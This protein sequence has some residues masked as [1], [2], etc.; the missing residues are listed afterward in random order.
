[1]RVATVGR[2]LRVLSTT[3]IGASGF[4]GHGRTQSDTTF[5]WICIRIDAAGAIFSTGLAAYL[6]YG[7]SFDASN[8]GF[9]LNM[10]GMYDANQKR[11]V[12][13]ERSS[14]IQRHDPL[15]GPC[16]Q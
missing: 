10:A 3:S 8:T 5:R 9:S 7:S 4:V 6:V 2:S 12:A 11:Y 16:P 13:H 1:M 14:W 15:V